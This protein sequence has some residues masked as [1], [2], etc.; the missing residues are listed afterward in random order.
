MNNP[1]AIKDKLLAQICY[2]SI[3]L[4]MLGY[5]YSVLIH[6]PNAPLRRNADLWSPGDLPTN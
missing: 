4:M 5:V 1:H 3:A 2:V 6:R